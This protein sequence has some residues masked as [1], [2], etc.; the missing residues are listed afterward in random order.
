MR[1]SLESKYRELKQQL[2]IENFSGIKPVAVR[3]DL[4]AALVFSNIV[5]V[6][7]SFVDVEIERDTQDRGNKWEYQANRNFLIGEVKKK[8]HLLLGDG[9][10][11]GGTL[12][13]IL[14][15]SQR[16]RSPIRPDRKE[17]R[18]FRIYSKT[19]VYCNNQRTAV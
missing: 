17:E 6:L 14:F 12:E 16:E 4:Y 19:S 15:L 11:A 5:S 1:W 7:K 18:T 8:L 9:R 13:R 2:K 10:A 3:Q